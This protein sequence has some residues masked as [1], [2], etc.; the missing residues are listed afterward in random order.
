MSGTGS[1]WS[2]VGVEFMEPWTC[3]IREAS[4]LEKEVETE[5]DFLTQTVGAS[6]HT[7]GN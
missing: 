4:H 7:P 2:A 6:R 1:C 3:P 5:Q